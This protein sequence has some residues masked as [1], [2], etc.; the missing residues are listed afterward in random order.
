M[1]GF[2]ISYIRL[3]VI[4]LLA[5]A[6]GFLIKVKMFSNN[7]NRASEQLRKGERVHI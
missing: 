1:R 6:C 3:L 4:T 7:R 5:I 2:R